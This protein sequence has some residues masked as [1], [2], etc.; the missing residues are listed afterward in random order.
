MRHHA[1]HAIITTAVASALSAV[2]CATSFIVPVPALADET[3]TSASQQQTGN[4][5]D[6]NTPTDATTDG[7]KSSGVSGNNAGDSNDADTGG[8]ADAE[9]NAD[10][11]ANLDA[12]PVAESVANAA[13]TASITIN[14]TSYDTLKAA[15]AAAPNN[16]VIEVAGAFAI[17]ERL[18]LETNKTVTIRATA[19]TTIT[20]TAG[21]HMIAMGAGTLNLEA[22]DDATFTLEGENLASGFSGIYVAGSARITLGRN[23]RFANF[24]ATNL[25]KGVLELGGGT[26]V[27]NGGVMSGCTGGVTV[28]TN[29]T[30]EINDGTVNA[31][32]MAAAGNLRIGGGARVDEKITLNGTAKITV[33]ATL[34]AYSETAPLTLSAASLAV[35][36][37][38]ATFPDQKTAEAN[39]TRIR[40]VDGKG[41]AARLRVNATAIVVGREYELLDQINNPYTDGLETTVIDALNSAAKI[42]QARKSLDDLP[43]TEAEKTTYNTRLDTL[44]VKRQYLDKHREAVEAS[45]T[46]VSRLG[47]PSTEQNRTLQGYIYDNT[48][49]T[50]FFIRPGIKATFRI[51]VQADDPG[52]LRWAYRQTGQLDANNPY[53][54]LAHD[55]SGLNN[56]MNEVTVDT[57]GHTVGYSL[58]IRNYSTTSKASIRVEDSG[59]DIDHPVVG[60]NVGQYPIYIHD[61]NH[62]EAFWTYVQK[63]REYAK[64]VDTVT[65]FTGNLADDNTLNADMTGMRFG[66]TMFG[67]RAS[68]TAN[69]T[70]KSVTDEA[71]A[72]AYVTKANEGL[73]SRLAYFDHL[74]G[75]DADDPDPVQHPTNMRIVIE[76]SKNLTNPSYYFAWVYIQHIHEGDVPGILNDTNPHSWGVDHEYGHTLDISP[77]VVFEETNNLF[78]MWGRRRQEIRN[79][80]AEDREY[81]ITTYHSGIHGA[82]LRNYRTY[83]NAS[84]TDETA[85]AN[86]SDVFLA[87]MLRWQVLRYF[88]DYDYNDGYDHDPQMV[89]QIRAYG[90]LGTMYRL[91]RSEPTRYNSVGDNK[92]DRMVAAVSEITGFNMAEAY[93]R[94]GLTVGDAAREYA[95]KYPSFPR[96]IEYYTIASDA[97]EINGAKAYDTNALPTPTV[98]AARNANGGLD[99]TATLSAGDA[100]NTTAYVLNADGKPVGYSVDGTFTVDVKDTDRVPDYTVTAYDVRLNASNAGRLNSGVDVKLNVR[101]IG[102][103]VGAD[104]SGES[105]DSGIKAT[106]TPKDSGIAPYD[107][108]LHDGEMTLENVPTATVTFTGGN[109]HTVSL[110]SV[111]IDAYAWDGRTVSVALVRNDLTDAI[112]TTDR[113]RIRTEERDG[114]MAFVISAAAGATSDTEVY[115]TIDGSEPTVG[116]GMR[117]DMKTG[118][119]VVALAGSPAIVKA[120]AYAFGTGLKPSEVAESSWTA[121]QKATLR[122]DIWNMGKALSLLPGEYTGADQLGELFENI[123][124]FSLPKGY[125]IYLYGVDQAGT[126][127]EFVFD[128]TMNWFGYYV[129]NYKIHTVRIEVLN[130]PALDSYTVKFDGGAIDGAAGAG[131]GAGDGVISGAM[132]DLTLHRGVT[133]PLPVPAYRAP[134]Y[135][136]DGWK[137]SA[138]NIYQDGQNVVDLAAA[139]KSVTLTAQ[140]RADGCSDGGQCAVDAYR[141]GK[142][143]STWT[144]PTAPANGDGSGSTGDG[145][146]FAG[147]YVDAGHTIPLPD[148]VTSGRAYAKFVPVSD[149]IGFKGGSMRA[150]FSDT[151]GKVD[152]AST[153]MRLG[154]AIAPTSGATVTAWGWKYGASETN[155]TG[156]AIGVNKIDGADNDGSFISNLVVK[157]FASRNYAR[158]VYSRLWVAYTTA[159]G[160]S[161][162]V[163]DGVRSRSIQ[164]IAQAILA[165]GSGAGDE[166]REY[167]QG[168]L[169]QIGVTTAG[170]SAGAAVGSAGG[171]GKSDD[172]GK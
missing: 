89:E 110:E 139:G 47:Y 50:G 113:P 143:S 79:M 159:D 152:Y 100:T 94:M 6:G 62:P 14:G 54:V 96:P 134:G 99:I 150:D 4:A 32:T 31:V 43:I 68:Y 165:D 64:N 117:L 108:T 125:R 10:A 78:A 112:G 103:G 171:A 51:Y 136:F 20:R 37:V 167:A 16:S 149:V 27:F 158:T 97:Q 34:T 61:E 48:D 133:G 18:T 67:V 73:N 140:W 138:G 76:A 160:T 7:D 93:E 83:L 77:M 72:I 86:W 56:G 156:S 85:T 19:N 13:E 106:V 57:T 137:D 123:K 128:A 95:A 87:V 144:A 84:L 90:T 23:V 148:R 122:S 135:R 121:T 102:G 11:G 80:K 65:G 75:F 147:W 155:L 12:A 15:L 45:V 88:D 9:K 130:V 92:R 164:G 142:D 46:E 168:I 59:A 42:K 25:N 66:R 74:Q 166:E 17:T 35:D 3:G 132:S 63:L 162:T 169:G 104:G 129:V 157:G 161:V 172:G 131:A 114:T 22:A 30:I 24:R 2:L 55:Q 153:S 98:T 70:L 111:T 71:S 49:F 127:K 82:A 163:T 36:R 53:L 126:A 105:V 44:D 40:A 60:D 33:T 119:A 151:S 146:A 81:R 21:I 8:T 124:S 107:V 120:R 28:G 154:Y 145:M 5:T 109:G 116:N 58:V 170:G 29:A 1:R 91:I 101:M 141:S 52:S 115:Y 26:V 69:T 38:V 41:I 118:E 39:L